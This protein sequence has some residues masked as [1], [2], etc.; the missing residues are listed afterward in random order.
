MLPWEQELEQSCEAMLS[1]I[2][3][4]RQEEL[5]FENETLT[6]DIVCVVEL[7]DP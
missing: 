7:Q 4:V 1:S 2:A 5:A 3:D 6:S